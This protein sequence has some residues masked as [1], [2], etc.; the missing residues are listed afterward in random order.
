MQPILERIIQPTQSAFIF[1]QAIHD[2][3]LVDHEVMNTFKH[4]KGKKGHAVL[5]LDMKKAHDR[6]KWDFIYKCLQETRFINTGFPRF[7]NASLQFLIQLLSMM[8]PVIF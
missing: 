4:M 8:K 2:N 3:I 7:T 1:H 6:M 5:K